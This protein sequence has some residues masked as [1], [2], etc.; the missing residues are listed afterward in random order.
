[1]SYWRFTSIL[2]TLNKLNH[3]KSGKPYTEAGVPQSNKDMI[4]RRKAQR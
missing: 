2:K 4:S 1:M 3:I